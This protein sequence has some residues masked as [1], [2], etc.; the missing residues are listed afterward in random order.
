MGQMIVQTTY[1]DE[2]AWINLVEMR[3]LP[4]RTVPRKPLA[5]WS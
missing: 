4:S 1:L 2:G 5:A 3:V